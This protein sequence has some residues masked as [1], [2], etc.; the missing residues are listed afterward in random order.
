MVVG[1]A[2]AVKTKATLVYIDPKG[3]IKHLG[4]VKPMTWKIR[5]DRRIFDD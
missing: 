2:G 1:K 3:Y 5:L 4:G